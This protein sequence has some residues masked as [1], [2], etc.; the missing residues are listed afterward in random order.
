MLGHLPRLHRWIITVVCT[1]AGAAVGALV[2]YRALSAQPIT[3][4][5]VLTGT[6]VAP[7]VNLIPVIAGAVLGLLTALFLTYAPDG[8]RHH[9]D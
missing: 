6:C 7:G 9:R 4:A 3:C 1:I 5:D 2:S 8:R